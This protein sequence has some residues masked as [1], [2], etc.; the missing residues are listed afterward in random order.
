MDNKKNK[1]L[2]VNSSD[3]LLIRLIAFIGQGIT[4]GVTQYFFNVT[5]F[6]I[7]TSWAIAIL[8]LISVGLAYYLLNRGE[9]ILTERQIFLF[10]C[11]DI[12]QISLLIGLNGGY[13]NP[14]IFIILAPIAIAASYL[15][16]ERVLVIL[17]LSLVC[18]ALIFNFYIDL[19]VSV[20]P[21]ININYSLAIMIS[22]F[23]SSIFLVFYLYYFSMNY[24]STQ[25]AYEL[26]SKQLQNE[27]ELLKVGGLAAAAVHELGTPL[28]TINLIVGDFDQ[29]LELKKKYGEDI[30]TLKIE[31]DRC[32][33]ILKEL[34]TNPESKEISS[35]IS[36][37]SLD[38]Y[39]QSLCDQFANNYRSID[40]DYRSD[41]QSKAINIKITPELNI[42][43]NNI[44]KNAISFAEKEILLIAESEKQEYFIK[45]RDDGPGFDKK[46][47]ANFGKPFYSSRPEKGVNMGLGLFITKQMIENLNGKIS[48]QNNNGAEVILTW[49]I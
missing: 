14:F 45:I 27:R 36:N 20:R 34:S 19:P 26:A 1:F 8:L 30:D 2:F 44:I 29:D 25:T 16:I 7:Y 28:N 32:K 22:L 23:I 6:V 41:E 9:K 35:E 39:V 24:K 38:A 31:L 15:T 10:L 43:M 13:T 47:I 37:M 21:E 46:F 17:S 48:V 4:L 5:E 42:A 12:L 49:Q 3:F 33:A 40:L 18:F 11:F